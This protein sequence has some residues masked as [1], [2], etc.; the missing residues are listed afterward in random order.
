MKKHIICLIMLIAAVLNINVYAT[1]CELLDSDFETIELEDGSLNI[2]KY[3]GICS[4]IELPKT[5]NNKNISG[6]NEDAFNNAN[7]NSIKI[8]AN[9]NIFDS[10]NTFSENII[11]KGLKDSNIINYAKKYERNYN[12]IYTVSYDIENSNI[13]YVEDNK[14]TINI[15]NPIKDYYSFIGWS[16][17]SN[18]YQKGS[19]IVIN[20]NVLLVPVW[21]NNS[22]VVK[23][24]ANG[25]SG[26]MNSIV[27]STNHDYVLPSVAFTKKNYKFYGWNTMPNGSGIS[28]KN[29]EDINN[30]VK[31][32]NGEI[33]LYAMWGN[34]SNVTFDA[35][36]GN[37]VYTTKTVY[38]NS[39]VGT[40]PTT[41]RKGYKFTGWYT[42]DGK[43]I[44]ANTI[45]PYKKNIKLY[46]HW[47]KIKYSISYSLTGEN[48]LSNI[49]EYSITISFKFL[50]PTRKG[51]KFVGWYKDSKYRKRITKITKGSTGNLTLY[52]KWTPIKYS[53]SF[54]ANGGTGKMFKIYNVEY[55]KNVTL[56]KNKF[57]KTGYKFI[58]WNTKVDGTGTFYTNAQSV[59][60]L[61]SKSGKTVKLYAQWKEVTYTITYNFGDGN[62]YELSNPTT[63]TVKDTFELQ[64]PEKEG[65]LFLGWCTSSSLDTKIRVVKKGTTGNKTYY[66]KWIAYDPNSNITKTR[67]FMVD[68]AQSQ[69]GNFNGK[70]YWTWY[71]SKHRM[72]WCCVFVSWLAD[73]NGILNVYIPKFASASVGEKY[74]KSR[75]Q[76]KKRGKYTPLPGDIVFFDWN[77][78]GG[79]DHVGI[80]EKV[81]DGYVYTIEGNSTNR[82]AKRKYKLT[83]YDINGYGI[84][85]YD[86]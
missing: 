26:E 40:L 20:D 71:G 39:K 84:P 32:N 11:L 17:G 45:Y 9:I 80:V 44:D 8:I 19:T 74:F 36:G 33:T 66:A 13:I 43:L 55:N 6:I 61:T 56:T 42:S 28:Y 57:K 83:S 35:K 25:G 69:I 86:K 27:L 81:K 10:A 58:G 48:N 62:T 41:K 37:R 49:T 53:I 22:Y 21:Q 67:I 30:L 2:V 23:F 15:S 34:K 46:A 65:Y 85:N 75:N 77:H 7:I 14:Y 24:D 16:N 5:I 29:N 79:L 73:Q 76:Y 72:A 54:N 47:K 1:E 31:L 52:A 78:N 82:V 4:N 12:E 63:Y 50:N 51:Y 18:T 64:N 68:L 3:N 70:K 59:K 38:Y 60:N